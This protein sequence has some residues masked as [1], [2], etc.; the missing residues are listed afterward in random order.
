MNLKDNKEFASKLRIV[1]LLQIRFMGKKD[2]SE[3]A[4][5]FKMIFFAKNILVKK[6]PLSTL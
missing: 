3:S 2:P 5:F 1:V 6:V 4:I